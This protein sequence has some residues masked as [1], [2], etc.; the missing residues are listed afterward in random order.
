MGYYG[1]AGARK[2]ATIAPLAPLPQVQ[3]PCLTDA[4]TGLVDCGNWA[5]SARWPVPSGLRV[6]DLLRTS[7]PER[8][9]RRQPHLLR[10]PRRRRRLRPALPD[11]GHD[12][13]GVQPLRR[14]QPL[15]RL[16]GRTRLQGELQ[17]SVHDA[18]LRKPVV[19][20]GGRVPDGAL[21]RA[22]RVRRQLLQRH[23]H[24]PPRRR[25]AWSTRR[26][27]PSVTTST[28]RPGSE[29]TSRRPRN[30]GVSLA[31]FSSQRDLL[32]D[33][34]GD[35]RSTA[36]GR[37]TGRSS[38]TRRRTPRA[39][40]DPD[41]RRGRA[42]GATPRFSPP[43]TADGRRTRSPDSCSRSTRYRNDPM[44]VPAEFASLRLWRNTSVASLAA[45]ARSRRSPTA[46]SATSSTRTWT[47]ATALRGS[48]ASPSTTLDVDKHLIDEGNTYVPG[49][50]THSADDVPALERR[51]RLRRRHVPVVV[52]ARR[53]ARLLRR[54]RRRRRRTSA[55]SRRR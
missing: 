46:S 5:E 43:P 37:P 55:S 21:A 27:S 10:R 31:F 35:R 2:V 26:S 9:G 18:G 50:A 29:P 12:L 36:P 7:R 49:T 30:A 25:A 13:A 22:Q 51:T 38:P 34:L 40:I 47:T 53:R 44:R 19:R 42:P 11:L 14:E 8:H 23:R 1:G 45:R 16:A 24:R 39:K 48:S 4:S 15:R 6:G 52:G 32:E 54:S 33:A 41:A 3:P 17:P 20:L 28:G